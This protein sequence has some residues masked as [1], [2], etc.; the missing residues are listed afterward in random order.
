M[1]AI[2]TLLA[3]LAA[4][5]VAAQTRAVPDT[6]PQ[7]QFSFAPIVKRAAPSVVN[8]Y[9]SQVDRR[10]GNRAAMEE[11]MRRFFGEGSG[12]QPERR[13][14]SL[15]SGVIVDESGLVVTNNH[16]IEN[17]NEVK[18]A[19][20]D[21]R[22]FEA[23][24][25][26]R[27]TRTDLAV[28]K[29]KNPTG[30]LVPMAFGDSEALEVG[31]FVI[32]IG[33]PFGVG[34]T[35]TQG[36]VSALARTLAGTADYQFFIQTDAAINPGNSG[37]ALIDQA[38][39]L[40][41]INT[42]IYSQSGGSHGIGFAIPSS[43]VK[44][45]VESA[46]GG[47]RAVKR[48]W[49]GARMQNVTPDIAESMGLERP[50]GVLVSG[51]QPNSPAEEAGLARG[52]VVLAVDGQVIDDPDAFGYRFALKG[53]TGE[54]PLTVLRGSSRR[55]MHVRLAA[56]PETRPR[57][58]LKPKARSPFVGA[59]ALNASPAVADELQMDLTTEGVVIAEVED[60]SVAGRAGLQK[61]DIV[62]GVN[63]QRVASTKDLDRLLKNAPAMWEISISRGGQVLTSLFQG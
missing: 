41:G 36:I 16:V 63:G 24:I 17:M 19:L 39:R 7:V 14:S 61:G 58:A 29:L 50:T 26:L 27:D 20:A 31:D 35:V 57:E 22:E 9:G 47:A 23:Q 52:D 3:A 25:L 28:L 42:A 4:L 45:V 5:P 53:V 51:V 2:L 11:F 44:A 10:G 33:N 48:P 8:V 37:G 56:P 46:K 40:I 12:P 54:T 59:T 21:R 30:G 49:L 55:T 1:R 34:Q 60:G 43:M 18:V 32:A 6:K 62:L 15:G 13:A 38:G